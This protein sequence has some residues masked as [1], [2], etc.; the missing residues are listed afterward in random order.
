MRLGYDRDVGDADARL[1]R[2]RPLRADSRDWYG[3]GDVVPYSVPH[4]SRIEQVQRP[5]GRT[6]RGYATSSMSLD[7]YQPTMPP[8]THLTRA[9]TDA[10][11]RFPGYPV[12]EADDDDD[13]DEDER[14]PPLKQRGRFP[15]RAR[16]RQSLRKPREPTPESTPPSESEEE[17][18][19]DSDSGDDE[20]NDQIEVVVEEAEE[21][22]HGH[23]RHRRRHRQPSR[24]DY[25]SSSDNER[26]RRRHRMPSPST[27]DEVELAYRR[28]AS[29]ERGSPDHR[30]PLR[31]Q[32]SDDPRYGPSQRFASVLGTSRPPV[33]SKRAAKVYESIEITREARP[34]RSAAL[35]TVRQSRESSLRPPSMTG[36]H[37]GESSRN[38]SPDRPRKLRDCKACL[39]EV[40]ESRCPK[41]DCGHR[42]CHSC[43]KRRFKQSM[44]D[45]EQMPP[46][47]CSPD[48]I[49]PDIVERLFD[50]MFK[51]LWN[52]K[53]VDY[54]LRARLYCPSRRCGEWI[55][56]ANV[57]RD[58]ETGRGAA[59]CDRCETK[60]CVSCNGRWHF[61]SKCPR[62]DQ[63][64]RFLEYAR[65][66]GRKRCHKC[67]ATAE[68]GEGDNHA[69]CRCGADFCIVCG[70]KP[71]RCECPWFEHDDP[72]LDHNDHMNGPPT[73]RGGDIQ[74]FKG[75]D[76]QVFNGGDIQV[77]R[78]E[79]PPAPEES[80]TPRR[81]RGSARPQ[82]YDE[83]ALMRQHQEQRDEEMARRSHYYDREDD[84][85][86]RGGIA[87][88]VRVENTSGHYTK[89]VPRR[90]GRRVVGAPP[91][92]SRPGFE[93][94]P[95][96]DYY[97]GG[98]HPREARGG[99]MDRR[100]ADRFAESRYGPMH[101][102]EPPPGPMG[103]SL[104]PPPIG[105]PPPVREGTYYGGGMGPERVIVERD[106]DDNE[107]YYSHSSRSRKSG[108][109]SDTPKSSELAGLSGRSSGL[110]RV[111]AWRTYVAPG[112]PEGEAA[113]TA[114]SA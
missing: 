2:R 50:P 49:S 62:D 18:D 110:G 60:V 7:A 27:S 35:Q 44:T 72:D 19:S 28:H 57:Y 70:Q 93:N 109:R 111:D 45:P 40:P 68:L 104:M 59:R 76:I 96:G 1:V 43:L 103:A 113:V 112:A 37:F 42:M 108:L 82:I 87:D 13:N 78:D 25:T 34:R 15:E 17:S 4:R 55:R 33:S 79:A 30:P 46:T 88:V 6:P 102:M 9:S 94:P 23:G 97:A 58:R 5:N 47:C 16:P 3:P 38:T 74:V 81:A 53:F 22:N 10:Y 90:T 107:S 36:S 8:P 26:Q 106:Y 51:K 14:W 64:A 12:Y 86:D 63:T 29:S 105:M 41:L 39:D 71:K 80:R 54:S 66:E 31:R 67:G 69:A 61:S 99:S 75:G 85:E 24:D 32:V 91:S 21:E 92:P 11:K 84:Y 77:F 100:L 48:H 73:R 52:K 20:D 98:E 95:G 56:P 114:A 65:H 101:G 89:D 83:E